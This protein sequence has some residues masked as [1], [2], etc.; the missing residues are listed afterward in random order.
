[1]FREVDIIGGYK[2]CISDPPRYPPAVKIQFLLPGIVPCKS[3]LCAH[4]RILDP[5]GNTIQ[6]ILNFSKSDKKCIK[7]LSKMCTDSLP[8]DHSFLLTLIFTK[9][10]SKA[11]K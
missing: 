1:M 9:L 8:T 3:F 2:T 10:I 6:N 7:N 4:K 11:V 5:R